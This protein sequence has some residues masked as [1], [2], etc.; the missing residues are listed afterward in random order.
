MQLV[1]NFAALCPVAS[2]GAWCF[3]SR[4]APN[5][6]GCRNNNSV[7]GLLCCY[8][9]EW[10]AIAR[11]REIELR[12]LR[13]VPVMVGWLLSG[14]RGRAGQGKEG[15]GREGMCLWNGCTIA[16]A[17]GETGEWLQSLPLAERGMLN[18]KIQA[19]RLPVQS[20]VDP[21]RVGN[22]MRLLGFSTSTPPSGESPLPHPHA[23]CTIRSMNLQGGGCGAKLKP[24]VDLVTRQG[25]ASAP[26]GNPPPGSRYV[27]CN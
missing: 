26:R 21:G 3:Y 19:V 14:W 1:C 20:K 25:G 18:P 10:F 23:P 27:V 16:G 4:R 15:K 17:L 24:V 6:E 9:E 13:A 2:R 5:G 12:E 8:E 11:E 7:A 22:S